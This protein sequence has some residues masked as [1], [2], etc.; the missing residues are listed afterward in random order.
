[1]PSKAVILL[2]FAN[3]RTGPG[4]FLTELDKEM[5]RL[6]EILQSEMFPLIKPAA[7][8]EKIR[9]AFRDYKEEI[10][11]FH[12]G[13]HAE[14]EGLATEAGEL[15]EEAYT[16]IQGLSKFIG[17]QKGLRLAFLNGCNTLGQA[18][19]FHQAGIPCVIA[20]NR[21]IGDAEARRF[22]EEFY[23]SLIRGS[24]IKKSF[25]EAK[26][27]LESIHGERGGFR[28]LIFGDEKESK[29]E[30]FPYEFLVKAGS[31]GSSEESIKQ[32]AKEELPKNDFLPE[33]KAAGTKTYLLCNRQ[34]Y[35][36]DFGDE[37]QFGL[38]EKVRRPQFFFIHGPHEELP[39]SLA[40]R[41]YEFTVRDVLKRLKE[42]LNPGKY[43][44]YELG[45]PQKS[46][47]E[48]KRNRDLA[49]IRLQNH[50][51][52][53]DLD[54]PED[55]GDVL[56]RIGPNRR[57]VL[58]QHDIMAIHW[59]EK[60]P[61]FLNRYLGEFWNLELSASQPQIVVVFNLTYNLAKGLSGFFKKRE[62]KHI[63]GKL[64]KLVDAFDNCVLIKKLESVSSDEVAAWQ[65]EY[66]KEKPGLISELFGNKNKLPMAEI[67]PV[68]MREL[69]KE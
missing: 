2:A 53:K 34:E 18:K 55:G 16:H 42:P 11:I 22:S 47:F 7:S 9:N 28:S 6:G 1:M 29:E 8:G 32:W 14:A 39:G 61:E 33:K 4:R 44:R 36:N 25:E 37:L 19:A 43:Y 26:S 66:L 59:H 5:L 63:Q 62:D 20:T 40:D 41:F 31:E 69:K 50:F 38:K 46:D 23:K 27:S 67:E 10:K 30:I 21:E 3:D 54:L 12:Y 52:Q 45:F 60:M 35:V 57:I 65:G 68:L 17:L 13:G 15:H 48:S 24:S 64:E 51:E 58:I 56:K 49:F